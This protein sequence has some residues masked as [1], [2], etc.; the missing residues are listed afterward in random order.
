MCEVLEEEIANIYIHKTGFPNVMVRAPKAKKMI[1]CWRLKTI[2]VTQY[3]SVNGAREKAEAEIKFDGEL[4]FTLI[5]QF[6]EMM[7]AEI[8]EYVEKITQ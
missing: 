1:H 8:L 6:N 2:E 7:G 5:E 4:I 3:A